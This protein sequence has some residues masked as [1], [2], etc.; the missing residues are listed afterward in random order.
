MFNKNFI[1]FFV[2]TTIVAFACY[3]AEAQFVEEGLLSYWSFEPETIEDNIVRDVMGNY[4]G[5]FVESSAHP[6]PVDGCPLVGGK[7]LDFLAL[8]E[9]AAINLGD[10]IEDMEAM[11][12]MAWINFRTLE[13]SAAGWPPICS[14]KNC[15]TFS[16]DA[17]ANGVLYANNADGTAFNAA[18]SGVT[19]LQP[20]T[21]YH[22]AVAQEGNM[23]RVY[24]H[25]L[26]MI[27]AGVYEAPDYGLDG[28]GTFGVPMGGNDENR[29]IGVYSE[30]GSSFDGVIDEVCIY[31]RSLT[32]AEVYQSAT[33]KTGSVNSTGKLAFTWGR[34]KTGLHE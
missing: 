6:Q 1:V 2:V 34:I 11:T 15:S 7:A 27:E 3:T 29:Y 32:S 20:N 33:G 25:E 14:K 8:P 9:K 4:D 30:G 5:T 31:D 12:I 21:W 19:L 18:V 16:I 24:V 17:N 26:S 22:V 13:G 28:S 10:V 23:G